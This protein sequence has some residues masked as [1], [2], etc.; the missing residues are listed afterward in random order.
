MQRV[1]KLIKVSQKDGLFRATTAAHVFDLFNFNVSNSVLK[2]FQ[3]SPDRTSRYD[4]L[5]RVSEV[6]FFVSHSWSCSPWMKRLALCHCLNLNL[7]IGSCVLAFLLAV[8][9]LVLHAGSFPAVAQQELT[10]RYCCLLLLPCLVFLGTYLFG[11]LLDCRKFWI[12][13]VCVHPTNAEVKSHMLQA[14]P[15]FVAQ[16]KQ[17]LVIWDDTYWQRLWCNYEVAIWVKASSA[18]QA[19]RFVPTWMPLCVLSSFA[20]LTLACFSFVGQVWIWKKGDWDSRLSYVASFMMIA[21]QVSTA[22]PAASALPAFWLGMRKL[23]KHK[24]MLHQMEQFDIRSAECTVESDRKVIEE[25]ILDLFDEALEPPVQVS[26]GTDA[27]DDADAP[28]ISP[29]ALRDFRHIT[30]YPT[31]DEIL[32]QFNAY[33]RGPLR[34]SV[35]ASI[36]KENFLPLNSCIAA[37]LPLVL[38]GFMIALGCDGRADCKLS[39]SNWGYTSVTEYMLVNAFLNGIQC[40]LFWTLTFPLVLQTSCLATRAIS[41]G[42]WQTVVGASMTA[43]VLAACSLS[44]SFQSVLILVVVIKY[45]TVWLGACVASFAVELWAF[46]HLFFRN[47]VRYS[48]RS[49]AAAPRP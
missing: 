19:I 27:A 21:A 28:L 2:Y 47:P 31:R 38:G 37:I 18:P 26:F 20:F 22:L 5:Q 46:W 15:A 16:S 40:P 45:S 3:T 33:V 12:D 25:Q 43:L 8:L 30:S 11:H 39:A 6:D 9:I 48:S 13:E 44:A 41:S 23:Q 42:I 7:A 35:E 14:I 10:L 34:E 1:Q 36:G 17:M 49:F 29:Q 4:S 24:S 32:D